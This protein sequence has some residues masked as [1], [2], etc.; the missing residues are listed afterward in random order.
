MPVRQAS[1]TPVGVP[2]H[3]VWAGETEFNAL[4]EAAVEDGYINCTVK[5]KSI[6]QKSNLGELEVAKPKSI[7]TGDLFQVSIACSFNHAF[8]CTNACT[9]VG[10]A[11]WIFRIML[12]REAWN[13]ASRYMAVANLLVTDPGVTTR[14]YRAGNV[15]P[16]A[17]GC[18]TLH[19]DINPESLEGLD[20]YSHVWIIFVFHANNNFHDEATLK[21]YVESRARALVSKALH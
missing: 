12:P 20:E 15:A 2:S 5:D 7:F 4:V 11:Y 6:R 19:K 16:F 14:F 10:C 3:F 8:L 21:V 9:S 18:L 1:T 13:T 17:R